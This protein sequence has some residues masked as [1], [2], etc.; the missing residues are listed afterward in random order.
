M[1][2][3]KTA[4]FPVWFSIVGVVAILGA[5]ALAGRLIWEQTV[6]TWERGPQMVGFSLAHG[7][8]ALLLLSPILLIVWIIP[9]TILSLI[10]L[11]NR[12]RSVT[13]VWVELGVALMI[14]ALFLLPYGFWQRLF[15]DRLAH[16]SHAGEFMTYAAAT[17]DLRTVK[18]LLTHGAPVD[19][20]DRSGKT[21][22]HTAAVQGKIN[23]M[24]YLISKGANIN[25]IDRY[26]DSP[27]EIAITEKHDDAAKYLSERG[28]Q[29]FRGDETTRDKASKDI[30]HEDIERMDK[31][32]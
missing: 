23:V 32:K 21:G 28:A 29:R 26:G 16:G 5:G 30:V 19:I 25:A 31:M 27:L 4:K 13:T 3:E 7:S 22:L 24:E 1:K 2:T 11:F 8:G 15:A 6:W 14:L 17:G 18:A 12:R 10:H 20:T 9:A